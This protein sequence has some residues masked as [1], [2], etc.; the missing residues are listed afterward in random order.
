MAD[1]EFDPL[2]LLAKEHAEEQS[3]QE[4]EDISDAHRELIMLDTHHEVVKKVAPTEKPLA[5][6]A[7]KKGGVKAMKVK[8]SPA[9]RTVLK[10]S[11]SSPRPGVSSPKNPDRIPPERA[12]SQLDFPF[13][14]EWRDRGRFPGENKML[15]CPFLYVSPDNRINSEG[16]L[17]ITSYQMYFEPFDL[18][19][20]PGGAKHLAIPVANLGKIQTKKSTRGDDMQV[21]L[22]ITT[23]DFRVLKFVYSTNKKF[24]RKTNVMTCDKVQQMLQIVAFPDQIQYLFAF[25]YAKNNPTNGKGWNIYDPE[26]EFFRM[27]VDKSNDVCQF[28]ITAANEKYKLCPTYPSV[29][30]VTKLISDEQ[31]VA[32]AAF[33]NKGRLP[34]LTWKIPGEPV[35]MFRCSQPKV[36]VTGKRSESDEFYLKT[37]FRSNHVQTEPLLW[38]MDCRP[39]LYAI[40]NQLK[41]AGYENMDNYPFAKLHFMGIDNIHGMRDAREKVGQNMFSGKGDNKYLSKIDGSGWLQYICL[42]LRNTCLMVKVMMEDKCSVVVHCSDG[43]D[44]TAQICALGQLCMDPYYRTIEGFIVLIEKDWLG[45]GHQFHTRCAHGASA[46]G[47]SQCSPIFSQYIEACAEIIRQYPTEFEFTDDFLMIILDQLYSCRFGTFLYDNV[48]Q[49]IEN[50]LRERT[51]SLW[52]YILN[53][54]DRD[55]WM[56]PFYKPT[57]LV[58][59]PSHTMREVRLWNKY[60][61]RHSPLN[62][63][64]TSSLKDPLNDLN[65]A[66][67]RMQNENQRLKAELAKLKDEGEVTRLKRELELLRKHAFNDDADI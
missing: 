23:R 5:H 49:R 13:E 24:S 67:K 19:S 21:S 62:M 39:K 3:Q 58:F 40:G 6:P 45:F 66:H 4:T 41:G 42:L 10:E 55:T 18:R 35:S 65:L 53:H 60:H 33:R 11:K 1:A 48:K 26:K 44:R 30:C 61:L 37:I 15:E 59:Y 38:I 31:L 51:V 14:D 20:I 50:K 17:T 8:T 34:V 52:Y 47:A 28:R 64:M 27:G 63:N 12:E 22:N 29:L 43:W 2:T 57:N 46:E 9:V 7:K 25:S 54:P 32:V 16:I 56:N 36:G